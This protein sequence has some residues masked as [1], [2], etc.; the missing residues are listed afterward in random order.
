MNDFVKTLEEAAKRLPKTNFVVSK[1]LYRSV[2][3]WFRDNF[4]EIDEA[5]LKA[6]KKMK[7]KCQLEYSCCLVV[8]RVR[9]TYSIEVYVS[10]VTILRSLPG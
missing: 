5:Y 1:M 7:L 10:L 4:D 9:A 3:I 2:P 6:I 8:L